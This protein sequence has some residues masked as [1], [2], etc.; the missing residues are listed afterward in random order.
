MHIAPQKGASATLK[1]LSITAQKPSATGSGVY[2][3]ELV[4]SWQRAGHTQAVVAGF[5]PEDPLPQWE[6]VRLFPVRYGGPG[7]PFDVVGM[8]DEMPYESTRYRDLDETR[9]AQFGE[10]FHRA[11]AGAVEA[12]Q[13]DWIVCHHLYL[14]TALVRQ[15]FPD[16]KVAGICHGS[17]LR[18][19]V[20]NPALEARILPWIPKLDRIVALQD[21]QKAEILQLFGCEERRV[22]VLGAGY[23]D[24]IFHKLRSPRR[25]P[26]APKRLLYAGKITEKKGIFS[27]FRALELLPYPCDLLQVVIAGG[28]GSPEES[29]RI[30]L[31][32]AESK[33]SI[34]FTGVLSQTELAGEFRRSDLFVL[35]SFYEGLPLVTL[36][37][38]ACGCRVVCTD[39]PGLRDWFRENIPQQKVE[40]VPLPQRTDADE[41]APEQLPRFER[42]LAQA[43]TRKLSQRYREY[44]DLSGVSWDGVSRRLLAF[45]EESL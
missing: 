29:R 13:P 2:L 44:P 21:A 20:K 12:V 41:I 37:A 31:M 42:R 17:D 36:E 6:G 35:P 1:I 19:M 15:W 40:F 24:R 16:R 25:D 22:R 7:L 14:L 33:Y 26:N 38:L 32:A 18:Q 10:A 28:F 9:L 39:L 27:L 4:R 34:E 11:V 30:R 45:L 3:S 8:S 23:N 43:L 5:A